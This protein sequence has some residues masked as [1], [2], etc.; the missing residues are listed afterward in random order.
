MQPP[1]ATLPA[2]KPASAMQNCFVS[3]V[4]TPKL[5]KRHGRQ[6]HRGIEAFHSSGKV[7]LIERDNGAGASVYRRF[8]YHVVIGIGKSGPPS[9]G[10][11]YRSCHRRQV[12][13]NVIDV[14]AAQSTGRQMLRPGEDRF[15]F[16]DQ[17]NG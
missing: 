5:L 16:E 12:V 8:Q 10:E 4:R 2:K 1:Y 15:V 13:Q 14:S 9:K 6:N 17:R 3:W 11:A 7:A